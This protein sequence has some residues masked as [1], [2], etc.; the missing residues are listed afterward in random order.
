MATP[1]PVAKRN[2]PR[3]AVINVVPCPDC[4]AEV[5]HPCVSSTGGPTQHQSRR[6]MAF[7]AQYLTP[8][9]A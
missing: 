7:R 4:G 9:E 6:R 2:L 5:G 3:M 8:Q 1:A